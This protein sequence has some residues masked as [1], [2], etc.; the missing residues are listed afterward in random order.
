VT[1]HIYRDLRL[2]YRWRLVA[3]NGR[4]VADSAEG[5]TRQHDCE[6]AVDRVAAAFTDGAAVVIDD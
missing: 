5:Y 4:I 1:V 2:E 3:D 6:Q